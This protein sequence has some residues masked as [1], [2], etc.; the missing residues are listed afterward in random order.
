MSDTDYSALLRQLQPVTPALSNAYP[1]PQNPVGYE[2]RP[3]GQE[4]RAAT[5]PMPSAADE[6][7]RDSNGEI[8]Y[9]SPWLGDASKPATANYQ[10]RVAEGLGETTKRMDEEAK[11]I[12][13][14][15]GFS[16]GLS[17]ALMRELS[18]ARSIPHGAPSGYSVPYSASAPE[19]QNVRYA[20]PARAA[21]P[22][23]ASDI[24]NVSGLRNPHELLQLIGETSHKAGDLQD[25][26]EKLGKM[27]VGEAPALHLLELAQQSPSNQ[28]S[29]IA[30][31]GRYGDTRLAHVTPEEEA[32]LQFFGG[33]GTTNPKTGL[34]E[35]YDIGSSGGTA[36]S[37]DP[38]GETAGQR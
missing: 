15:P 5:G 14:L 6:P 10:R 31:Q 29:D 4:L 16:G 23:A 20:M 38:R 34:K 12:A 33:A 26:R 8:I 35:F 37:G 13:A 27:G 17:D 7:L 28:Y 36:S 22:Q 19:L 25:L 32:L 11:L 3:T 1:A 24:T 30:A 21:L 2:G 18:V 9:Q